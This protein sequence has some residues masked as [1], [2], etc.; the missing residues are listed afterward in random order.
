MN[1]F[2]S[3]IFVYS[4]LSALLLAFFI[5]PS[6]NVSAEEFTISQNSNS[7]QDNINTAAVYEKY[8][9]VNTR[10]ST[11]P[12]GQIYHVEWDGDFKYAGTLTRFD[13]SYDPDAGMYFAIYKGNIRIQ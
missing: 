8:V 2:N 6:G 13:Y 5:Y 3:R 10:T 4:L 1:K 11:F 9:T 7:N 12:P